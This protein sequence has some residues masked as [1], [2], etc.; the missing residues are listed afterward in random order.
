MENLKALLYPRCYIKRRI[1]QLL[2]LFFKDLAVMAPSES[3][4]AKIESVTEALKSTEVTVWIPQPL[5]EERAKDLEAGISAL[6]K[7]GEQL[8]LGESVS[9][10]TFYSAI[11]SSQDKEIRSVMDA[12]KGRHD[13]DVLMASRAFLALSLEADKREDELEAE[14]EKVEEKAKT[15]SRLVEDASLL[16]SGDRGIYYIQPLSKARE[17]M[18]AWVRLAFSEKQLPSAWPV[19]E[20]IAIKD[21]MDTAYES[22]SKGKVPIDIFS[23]YI[24]TDEALLQDEDLIFKVRGM[25]DDMLEL[26]EDTCSSA[27]QDIGQ[28]QEFKELAEGIAQSLES[29]KWEQTGAPRLVLTIYEG[30]SWKH[31]MA[32]AAKLDQDEV[33]IPADSKEICASFFIV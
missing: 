7:W 6:T 17:R 26:V 16:P 4:K 20:S 10:E 2:G 28:N 27:I 23:T 29:E 8:G 32:H 3:E 14:I 18:R 31:I 30:L 19:G 5:G 15:I 22:L 12:L 1:G 9:F 24:P 21:L 25:F 13:E 33:S 11:N